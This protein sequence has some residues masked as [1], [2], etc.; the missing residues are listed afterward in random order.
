MNNRKTKKK[1]SKQLAV[2]VLSAKELE[3]KKAYKLEIFTPKIPSV[4]VR[5]IPIRSGKRWAL[6]PVYRTMKEAFKQAIMKLDLPTYSPQD[7]TSLWHFRVYIACFYKDQRALRRDPDNFLKIIQDGVCVSLLQKLFQTG[8]DKNLRN[9]ALTL[10]E[11]P[12]IKDDTSLNQ[13]I[14]SIKSDLPSS[15]EEE[16]QLRAHLIARIQASSKQEKLLGAYLNLA[17]VAIRR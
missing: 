17:L 7:F 1:P 11:F 15:F 5:L 10:E 12:L 6:H 14:D 13:A 16:D 9:L 2:Y 8:D 4:N 3:P